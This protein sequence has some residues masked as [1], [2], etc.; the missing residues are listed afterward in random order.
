[1]LLLIITCKYTHD[2]HGAVISSG[3]SAVL[4][5]VCNGRFAVCWQCSAAQRDQTA[6]GDG[7]DF[8]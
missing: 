1:M 7:D 2:V 4:I 8:V 6:G 3:G 5:W